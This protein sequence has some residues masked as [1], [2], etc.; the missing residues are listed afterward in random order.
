MSGKTEL[1]VNDTNPGPGVLNKQDIP[2]VYVNGA[3][4]K[5]NEFFLSKPIDTG[6]FDYDL[7]LHADGE[8]GLEPEELLGPRRLRA[9]AADHRCPGHVALGLD[10]LV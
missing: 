7:L 8:R 10:H 3:T 4:P 2:V 6:F 1:E 9:A 5:G